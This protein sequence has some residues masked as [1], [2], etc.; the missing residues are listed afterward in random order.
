MTGFVIIGAGQ[1]AAIAVRTLRRRGFDGHVEIIGAELH[2]PYQRP[3]LT[4]EYLTD[5][6]S[7]DLYLLPA[8]WCADNDVEL[9]LGVRATRIRQGDAVVE[10][11]DGTELA[12]DRVLLATGGAARRLPGVEGERIFYLR[13][14]DDADRLRGALGPG[15]R[16]VVIGSGFIGSEIAATAHGL[17]ADVTILDTLDVPMQRVLGR[18]VGLVCADIHRRNGI[19]VRLGERV[20]AVVEHADAVVV[21]THTDRIEGDVVVVGVGITPNVEVAQHS[22]VTIDNGVLVDEYCR[23]NIPNVFAAGDVANHYHPLFDEFM[24]VEHFD[25][26]NRQA[27][28]A[29]NNM[30][31]RPTVFDDPH[32]FWSDQYGVNLQHTGH[33]REWDEIVVRG[34]MGDLDFCAFYLRDGVIRSAFAVDRGEEI[35]AAKELIAARALADVRALK[36]EDVDLLT[37]L[38]DEE[39]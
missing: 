2:P 22:N 17:G 29:A 4:K 3:P 24:R 35:A 36:D 13:T 38:D 10:L 34:S 21:K 31:D 19:K 8:Q 26:A 1:T 23:T 16:L 6:D 7:E 37:L 14:L 27:A 33:A 12:A 32:W 11:A 20:D 30:L 18:E 39:S 5:A 15:T 28:A 9:R 25:N